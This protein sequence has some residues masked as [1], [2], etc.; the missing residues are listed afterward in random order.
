MT[1]R[2]RDVVSFRFI[3]GERGHGR[4]QRHLRP[5]VR[6][7]PCAAAHERRAAGETHRSRRPDDPG[8]RGQPGPAGR[9]RRGRG[10]H[11]HRAREQRH[12]LHP[13]QWRGRRSA[14]EILTLGKPAAGDAGRRRRDRR[15]GRRLVFR[16]AGS[17]PCRMPAS[18]FLRPANGNLP[19]AIDPSG[20]KAL[21]SHGH[22]QAARRIFRRRQRCTSR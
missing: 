19:R 14:A 13:R 17:S 15:R 20:T 7:R 12:P 4:S 2:R 3:S 8:G 21:H 16:A 9:A 11:V 18:A 5:A 10:R 6:R 22:E 1:F